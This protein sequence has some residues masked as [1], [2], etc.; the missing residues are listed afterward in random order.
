MGSIAEALGD[1]VERDLEGEAGLHAP[2]PALGPAGRLVGEVPGGVEAVALGEGGQREELAGVVRRDQAERGVGAA[3]DVGA[4]VDGLE[5]ARAVRAHLHGDAHRVAA[6]VGV[7]LL[8]ARVEELDGSPRDHRELRGAELQREGLA[9]AAEGSPHGRLDHPDARG[10]DPQHPRE[11]AVQVVRHLRRR[12]HREEAVLIV[13]TDR[14]VGLDGH[15][16][17]AFVVIIA[18]DDEVRT[19]EQCID[20]AEL[21]LDLLGDVVLAAPAQADLWPGDGGVEVGGGGEDLV[22]HVDQLGRLCGRCA[23]RS[24]RRP[25]RRHRRSGRALEGQRVLVGRP[26]DDPEALG[27]VLAGDDGDDARLRQRAR[28]VDAHD[29]RVRVRAAE[30]AAPEHAREVDVVRVADLPGDPRREQRAGAPADEAGAGRGGDDRRG[31]ALLVHG[32]L[33]SSRARFEVLDG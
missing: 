30:Q 15:V 8:L 21:E 3:V 19:G 24:R 1:L 14:A 31:D 11:L 32:Q 4:R 28:R 18:L 27:H 26:R 16:R 29:A 17:R 5:L 33:A 20:V 25:P 2:V 23:R 9:L 13:L 12:P 7:E 6:A 22:L 10:R